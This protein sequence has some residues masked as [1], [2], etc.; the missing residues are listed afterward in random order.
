MDETKLCQKYVRVFE[1]YSASV[2]NTLDTKQWAIIMVAVKIA[3]LTARG[4]LLSEHNKMLGD[5]LT[6]EKE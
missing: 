2:L 3:V 4:D 1:E 5:M 6:K